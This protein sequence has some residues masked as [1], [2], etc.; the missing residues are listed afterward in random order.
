MRKNFLHTLKHSITEDWIPIISLEEFKKNPLK[1]SLSKAFCKNDISYNIEE[2]TKHLEETQKFAQQHKNYKISSQ[3]NKTFR[4]IQI[5]MKQGD[6]VMISKNKS[7]A[8][9]FIIHHQKMI[10]AIEKS[11][12]L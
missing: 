1:L 9:H 3:R 10:Q 6:W 5:Q 11:L 12:F 8:I 2:Y 4:N 7:P